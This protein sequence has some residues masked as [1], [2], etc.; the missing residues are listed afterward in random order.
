M[1]KKTSKYRD[2]HQKQNL[3]ELY[4]LIYYDQGLFYNTPFIAPN[5]GFQQMVEIANRRANI[6]PGF[7]RKIF[8]FN[9]VYPNHEVAELWTNK[10]VI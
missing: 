2:L 6:N 7:F 1:D 8:L 4:L 5:F 3:D 10:S 9:S